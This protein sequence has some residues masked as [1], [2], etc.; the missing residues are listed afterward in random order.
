MPTSQNKKYFYSKKTIKQALL[1]SGVATFYI[2][3]SV[4]Y[5]NKLKN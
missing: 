5:L 1:I 3:L 2:Y 4:L